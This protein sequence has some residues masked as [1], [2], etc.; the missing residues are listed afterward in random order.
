MRVCVCVC[1]CACVCVLGCSHILHAAAH[2]GSDVCGGSGLSEK[3]HSEMVHLEM[4]Y[5]AAA[6]AVGIHEGV[7]RPPPSH[8]RLHL[9]CACIL[10]V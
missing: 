5:A 8:S 10:Y 1:V 7:A 4:V 9:A 2:H 6:A 3:V